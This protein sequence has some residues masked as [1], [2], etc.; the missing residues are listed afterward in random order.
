MVHERG[1]L[2]LMRARHF[3]YSSLFRKVLGR[4]L[5]LKL[6]DLHG[7]HRSLAW[8]LGRFQVSDVRESL[9][10]SVNSIP[11]NVSAKNVAPT[12]Q[13]SSRK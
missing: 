7:I 10:L 9:V 6:Y 13:G 1:P 12:F 5:S 8:I 4:P 3:S 11:N 2:S